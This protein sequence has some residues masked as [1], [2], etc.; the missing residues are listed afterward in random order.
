[1]IGALLGVV[2]IR[3]CG[4]LTEEM[5]HARK[6]GQWVIATGIGLHFNQSIVEQI[7]DHVVIIVLGTILTVTASLIGI[8]LLRRSGEDRATAFFASMPGG[9]NEMVNLAKRHNAILA[10][11]A[12]G[13]SL[14]MMLVLLSIPA[15]YKYLFTSEQPA[16]IQSAQVD[17][18]WLIPI[19]AIGAGMAFLF[20]RLRLPNAWQL[21]ALLVSILASVT[22]DL[23]I[24]LPSSAGAIGQWLIGSSLGCYF[25]RPF[26]RRAPAFMARTIL[27][28][29]L[30]IIVV[31][32]IAL[33][34]GW[35]T[36][37]DARSLLLGMVPG[38]IAEMSLTAEA[39][40]LMVPLV[41]AMQVLRLLVV[42]FFAQPV[43][44]LWLR[45]AAD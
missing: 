6:G 39:L 20:Q 19:M 34:L 43:Y 2:F 14:R 11:V 28:T 36:G 33:A 24:G 16:F 32:P 5:P 23:Q 29:V 30:A 17:L 22:F 25:D 15:T 44:R 42:L 38:G 37:L 41:T 7:A 27:A 21:G 18:L 9:A 10:R 1:M 8:V 12:A 35:F 31:I 45:R 40:H 26:F 3:C 13:Q 4:C